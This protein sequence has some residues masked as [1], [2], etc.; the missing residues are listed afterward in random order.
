MKRLAVIFTLFLISISLYSMPG[1]LLLIGGGTERSGMDG[2]NGEAFKWAVDQSENKKVAFITYSNSSAT[3]WLPDHFVSDWGAEEGQN[4]VITG[5]NADDQVIYDSL[6]NYDVIYFKGG[7]Q[8]QYYTLYNDTKTEQAIVDKFSEGGVICGTSAGLAILGGVDFTAINGSAYP[9]ECLNNWNNN[10]VTLHNDFLETFM[11]GIIFDTHFVQRGRF[12]RLLGFMANWKFIKGEDIAG[13]G[14]D[15][16]TAMAVDTNKVGTVYGTGC[17]N[18]YKTYTDVP[19]VEL[20]NHF[21]IDSMM[22]QQLLQGCTYD[23]KTGEISGFSSQTQ[24]EIKEE[25]GN[26]TVLISGSDNLVKNAGL[27]DEFINNSGTADAPVI[28][29]TGSDKSLAN[30]YQ[31]EFLSR[32]VDV[33]VYSTDNAASDVNLAEDIPETEKFLLVGNTYTDFFD[34]INNS[35]T[36]QKLME[37]LQ[38]EDAVSAFI[39]DNSRFAGKVAISGYKVSGANYYAEMEYKNGLGLFSTTTVM[40][41]TY[42]NSDYYENTAASVPYAMVQKDLT[43]G[44]W[45]TTDNFAKYQVDGEEVMLEPFGSM[46]VMVIRNR[47]TESGVS[48]QTS[49]GSGDPRQVAGF[50]NMNLSVIEGGINYKLGEIVDTTGDDN[51]DDSDTTTAVIPIEREVNLKIWQNRNNISIYWENMDYHLEV[52]DLAGK[53]CYMKQDNHDLTRFSSADM[54]SGLYIIRLTSDHTGRTKTDKIWIN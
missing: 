28:I 12:A 41:Y 26:F 24:P 23:F 36:G 6:M 52:I 46:P 48:Q 45:L 44:I 29:I 15:D 3:D 19:F 32:G 40:P 4:I 22:V 14:L 18:I 17:A 50:K 39:G 35:E 51:G 30:S 38:E 53:V 5:D 27:L 9:D 37:R 54:E 47:G 42:L 1:K 10:K 13:I 2:W 11:P 16:L 7:D 33:D 49:N 43:Y 20:G 21:V 8:S 25:T 31:D 34:F